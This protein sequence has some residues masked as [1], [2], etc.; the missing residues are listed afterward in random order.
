M[1]PMTLATC[2]SGWPAA[3]CLVGVVASICGAFSVFVMAVGG[4]WVK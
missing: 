4:K 3:F 2:D 1:Y